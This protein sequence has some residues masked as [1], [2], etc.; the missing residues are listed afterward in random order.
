MV[1]LGG[2]AASLVKEHG[3]GAI[4]PEDGEP[5]ARVRDSLPAG[6]RR[7]ELHGLGRRH[8]RDAADGDAHA[9]FVAFVVV[10]PSR[11][12]D[13]AHARVAQLARER[14]H[15]LHARL[16]AA[17]QFVIADADGFDLVPAAVRASM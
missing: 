11:A 6:A 4:F 9:R 7:G 3:G 13:Q 5:L 1:M 8:D 17:D 16:G 2:V 12:R 14:A 15:R 10:H